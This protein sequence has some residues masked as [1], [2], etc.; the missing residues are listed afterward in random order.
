MIVKYYDDFHYC[1]VISFG[2]QYSPKELCE[3]IQNDNMENYKDQK[4]KLQDHFD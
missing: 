2:H 1:D 4:G 3:L